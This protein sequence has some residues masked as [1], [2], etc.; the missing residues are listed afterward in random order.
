MELDLTIQERRTILKAMDLL[1]YKECNS[2]DHSLLLKKIKGL[3]I[4]EDKR[5]C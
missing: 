3:Y 1:I 5:K 4:E 2:V